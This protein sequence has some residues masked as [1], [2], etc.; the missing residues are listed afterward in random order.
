MSCAYEQ[1]S[2]LLQRPFFKKYRHVAS[3][4]FFGGGDASARCLLA[5]GSTCA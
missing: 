4:R 3:R 1:E 5:A 2:P